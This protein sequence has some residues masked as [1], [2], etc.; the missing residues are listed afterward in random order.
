MAETLPYG[1]G[2][3]KNLQYVDPVLIRV[4]VVIDPLQDH[5]QCDVGSANQRLSG[6][7]K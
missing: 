6:V 4:G 1:H 3:A 2:N 7:E 5:Y